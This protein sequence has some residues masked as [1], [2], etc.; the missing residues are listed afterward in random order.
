MHAGIVTTLVTDE[1]RAGLNHISEE[2]Q[3]GL[4]QQSEPQI[5]QVQGDDAEQAK[6]NLE[7]LYRL[8]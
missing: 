8:Y 3:L 1:E 2:L 5:L 4:E 7:D 6:R